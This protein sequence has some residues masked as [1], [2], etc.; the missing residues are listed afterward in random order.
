M[1]RP[2]ALTPCGHVTCYG[3]LVR[4]FTSDP[5]AQDAEQQANENYNDVSGLLNNAAARRGTFIR[6]RKT[7]PVC[8][9]S[10]LDRP[11]EMWDIK[12]MVAA[13]VKSHLVD[14]PGPPAGGGEEGGGTHGGG[15]S[16]ATNDPWRN[17]FRP[18]GVGV[19]HR[20]NL[21][22]VGPENDLVDRENLGWYDHED[23]GVYR[24]IDCFHEIWAGMCSGCQRIYRGHNEEEEEEEED[25]F[26]DDQMAPFGFYDDDDDDIEEDHWFGHSEDDGFEGL[27]RHGVWPVGGDIDVDGETDVD[28]VEGWGTVL[29]NAGGVERDNWRAELRSDSESSDDVGGGVD[30]DVDAE[31][32]EDGER[33]GWRMRVRIVDD[34]EDE[35]DEEGTGSERV[36][37]WVSQTDS[38]VEYF[39]EGDDEGTDVDDASG[40]GGD[41]DTE[42]EEGGVFSATLSRRGTRA[43]RT[44]V[45]SEESEDEDPPTP[46]RR[47]S[48]RLAVRGRVVEVEVESE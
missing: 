21:Q 18:R 6:R 1:H 34:E 9:G 11:V 25:L 44:L 4:W 36:R 16:N 14:L 48:I 30:V 40:D 45:S 3:C 29:R 47:R 43:R 33:S 19:G 39:S 41:E 35:E 10:V 8:R 31:S 2:Y 23:G 17:V 32:S 12:Q 7:C 38:H 46:N 20:A 5:N 27:L 22:P 42:G 24:C 13:L 28:S 37:T 26:Y 15:G